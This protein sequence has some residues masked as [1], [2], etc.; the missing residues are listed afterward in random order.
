MRKSKI[1]FAAAFLVAALCSQA[2]SQNAKDSGKAAPKAA[3]DSTETRYFATLGDILGDLPVEAF[4]KETRQGGKVTSALI[5]VCYSVTASSDRKDRFVVE[6]K[7]EGEKLAGNGQTLESKA[8]VTVNLLRKVANKAIAFE[9]KITVGGNV[10]LV[11]SP[12][13]TD[14]G[15]KEFLQTQVVDDDLVEAPKDFTQVSPYSVGIRVKREG[16]IDL[17]KS[18][19][20]ENV[21]IALD[22]IATDCNALRTGQ[23]VLRLLVDPAR[24]AALTA[25]LKTVPGV[26]AAGWTS[27]TYDMERAVRFAAS[28]WSSGSKLDKD[29]FAATLSAVAAKAMSAKPASS[30]WNETTGE[31]TFAVKRPSQLAPALN[32]VETLENDSV[33]RTGK[34][35]RQRAHDCLGRHSLQQDRR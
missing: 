24:A 23:Q 27:G 20:S 33:D 32:L 14:V 7:S 28:D 11:S 8:P 22:S 1:G 13:N 35:R 30:K 29:K 17:V 4:I 3:S 31:M 34:T 10:S 21:Q 5:D 9:G 6:L 25:K 26:V 12:D 2:S 15:E 16:F 18:L 19:K